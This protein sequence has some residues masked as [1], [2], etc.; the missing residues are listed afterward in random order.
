MMKNHKSYYLKR[1]LSLALASS[2]TISMLPVNV[3]ANDVGAKVKQA[4]TS[5]ANSAGTYRDANPVTTPDATSSATYYKKANW[6]NKIKDKSRWKVEDSQNLV[7]V[8]DP[9][10]FK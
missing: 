10:Q 7:R 8:V 4:V 1:I 6:E 2:M 3:F 5:N 9:T